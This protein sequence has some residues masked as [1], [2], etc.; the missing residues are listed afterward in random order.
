MSR[1]IEVDLKLLIA[2]IAFLIIATVGSAF[3]TYLIFGSNTN[4][5]AMAGVEGES[6]K[7][8]DMGPI[9]EVGEF[10]LNLAASNS[11]QNHFIRTEIVLELSD[12]RAVSS[13][14]KRQPQVRDIIIS[15]VRSRTA[16]QFHKDTGM[17]LLRFE[18]IKEMN[19]LLS[20]GEVTNVYFIDLIVQ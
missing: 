9:Y 3:A 19:T 10:T 7:K 15:L 1:K 20:K 5:Q 8:K 4:P 2:A 16:E 14:E 11:R 12:R 13:L 17:E 18:I 6:S